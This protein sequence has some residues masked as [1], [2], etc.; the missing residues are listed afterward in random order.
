MSH[1]D[2]PPP[3]PGSSNGQSQPQDATLLM[4]AA[5][6]GDKSAADQLLPLVYDQLRKA[7][8]INMANE[9]SGH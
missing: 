5:A 2:R 1:T 9:R 8:Q 3:T 4:Q 7:A 6:A